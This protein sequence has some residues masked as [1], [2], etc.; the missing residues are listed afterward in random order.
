MTPVTALDAVVECD[1]TA[2]G[3]AATAWAVSR[4]GHRG[5]ATALGSQLIGGGFLFEGDVPVAP[6][7]LARGLV[8]VATGRLDQAD[9]HL[10]EAIE[11]GD[12]RAP[13][14]GALARLERSPASDAPSRCSAQATLMAPV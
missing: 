14:W 10:I 9:V 13:V 3:M 7:A 12:R 8:S 2:Q 4:V 5:V 11:T 1:W 6:V